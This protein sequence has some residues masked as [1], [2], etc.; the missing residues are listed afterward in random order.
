MQDILLE[1]YGGEVLAL[2]VGQTTFLTALLAGGSL[3][4]FLLLLPPLRGRRSP[5]P[6]RLWRRSRGLCLRLGGL[7]RPL[8]MPWLFRLG[9]VLIGVGGGFFAIGTLTAAMAL[10]ERVD[11]GLALGAWGAVQATAMGLAVGAGG[12]LRDGFGSLAEAGAL[13]PALTGAGS[14]LQHCLPP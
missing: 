7:F 5:P 12:A 8:A 3:L 6:S 10:A 4:A 9:T 14:G 2:N 13:G 1:P 11:S